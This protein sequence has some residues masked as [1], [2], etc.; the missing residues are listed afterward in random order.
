M[1]H[2]AAPK[3]AVAHDAV[4]GK[5]DAQSSCSLPIYLAELSRFTYVFSCACLSVGCL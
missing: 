5:H 2:G 1:R 4:F 3:Q